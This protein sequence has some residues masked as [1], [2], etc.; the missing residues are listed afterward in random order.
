VDDDDD[1]DEECP[2]DYSSGGIKKFP[3]KVIEKTPKTTTLK[4]IHCED[5]ETPEENL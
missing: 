5:D 1:D 2:L 4:S 3:Y